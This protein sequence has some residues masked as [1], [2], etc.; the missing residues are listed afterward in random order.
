MHKQ[1]GFTII[2]LIVVVAVIVVLAAIVITSVTVYINKSKDVRVKADIS[3]LVKQIII[4]NTQK[5]N[6]GYDEATH[7]VNFD[8]YYAIV[9]SFTSACGSFN[10]YVYLGADINCFAICGVLCSNNTHY[11]QDMSGSIAQGPYGALVG[12]LCGLDPN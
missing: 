12:T 3:Q 9:N 5:T 6:P 1:K 7:E 4:L 8:E 10:H 2:E 11:C